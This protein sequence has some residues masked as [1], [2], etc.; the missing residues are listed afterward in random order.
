MLL[1]KV[2][3]YMRSKRFF[4][5]I[6]LIF[7]VVMVLMTVCIVTYLSERFY[8]YMRQDIINAQEQIV[9]SYA[10][11]FDNLHQSANMASSAMLS[12]TGI[13]NA[14]Y[15][16]AN[17]P[18]DRF[19]AHVMVRNMLVQFPFIDSISIIDL[20]NDFAYNSNVFASEWIQ[21][22][23]ED[24]FSGGERLPVYQFAPRSVTLPG[25][26]ARD[27]ISMVIPIA[28][29]RASPSA[30]GVTVLSAGIII[31]VDAH[32]F[33]STEIEPSPEFSNN[34]VV[35][36]GNTILCFSSHMDQ[37]TLETIVDAAY[38]LIM[39]GTGSLSLS[40]AESKYLVSYH[41]NSLYTLLSFE[42][43]RTIF[44]NMN[45]YTSQVILIC[46]SITIVA[47]FI[48]FL[49]VRRT[50]HPIN[51]IID[52]AVAE[53][54][55]AGL[56]SYANDEI[57]YLL[58]KFDEMREDINKNLE[59]LRFSRPYIQN[60]LIADLLSGSFPENYAALLAEYFPSFMKC[61]YFQVISF[62]IY[63]EHSP[64]SDH[65]Q[66]EAGIHT[67]LNV[68]RLVSTHFA[69]MHDQ[70]FILYEAQSI[71]PNFADAYVLFGFNN[72]AGGMTRDT[73]SSFS[74]VLGAHGHMVTICIGS[75]VDSIEELSD[76]YKVA[77]AA[78]R[79]KFT[80]GLHTILDG[81][82]SDSL[83]VSELIVQFNL[84]KLLKLLKAS[85]RKELVEELDNAFALI[86][87][88]SYDCAML[89]INTLLFHVLETASQIVKSLNEREL[90]F[91]I[92][93]CYKTL[94]GLP[95]LD[96]VQVY[97]T[98]FV[99]I[100]LDKINTL[101]SSSRY[102]LY[103][104]IVE[105][106]Y[107]NLTDPLLSLDYL[108]SALN[109]S[110]GYISKVFATFSEYSINEYI[111]RSRIEQAKYL[112]RQTQDSVAEISKKVGFQSSTY[113]ITTFKKH[114]GATPN[115]YR[116]N[117]TEEKE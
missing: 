43:E 109:F 22:D 88:Y 74:Q 53:F 84:D 62:S 79:K 96:A 26:E 66:I 47:L 112:L 97:L 93:A 68:E 98:D 59:E 41:A 58:L 27:M 7:S 78:E 48:I 12:S 113:F 73:L 10:I 45:I 16:K 32:Y 56:F 71:R 18:Y 36:N 46:V 61:A 42:N 90:P 115:N 24:F 13:V 101:R 99:T 1:N 55:Q 29:H 40:V 94:A 114:M 89:M 30:P 108:G 105:Q 69:S 70:V 37:S 57:E 52:S 106:I 100:L 85:Q 81:N 25:K 44:S 50:Y 51:Y 15:G 75:V 17:H 14:F 19:V 38:P 83:P 95:T 2:K 82:S 91:D 102:T 107:A 116:K 23:Q 63:I 92:N 111:N 80:H 20:R 33:F 34:T 67:R 8:G 60:Q 35:L 117:P 28:Y 110:P 104:Q 65:S 31:N 4:L 21:V 86:R 3:F 49:L 39:K 11:Q 77:D 6:I 54:G 76:S 87:H 72:S 64:N 103:Q 9:S 5:K